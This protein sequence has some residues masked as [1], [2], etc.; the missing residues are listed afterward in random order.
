MNKRI[1]AYFGHHKCGSTWI[2]KVISQVCRHMGIQHDHYYSPKK[3]G[4]SKNEKNT[5]DKVMY[6]LN[7]D[8]IGYTGADLR[9][10][11]DI[12]KFRGVHIIRDPRDIITSAYFSHL[13][14][15]STSGWPELAKF[16][17][18]I[19][20]MSKEEGFLLNID[21]TSRLP[22]DGLDLDLFKS[23]EEWNYKTS[24]ILEMKYEDII[25][26]PYKSF[27][28][29]FDHFGFTAHVSINVIN[30]IYHTLFDSMQRVLRLLN[31]SIKNKKIP[32]WYILY[33]VYYND[34]SR[35]ARGR[36]QGDENTKSHFRKG[37]SG[38]W[39]NHFNDDHKDYFKKYYNEILVKLGY[40]N[41]DK[42]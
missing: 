8:F 27:I 13:H 2:M 12:N 1:P 19:G 32:E 3:W 31:L 18:E 40:E 5:L 42:W 24:N 38:D 14:S 36:T 34:F 23:M 25:I 35:L 6:D 11:G 20:N 26:N 9:Y 39:K 29:I 7:S 41:D 30:I 37:I 15:H 16:R 17:K 21:F 10:I 28:Q 4:Y 22:V 33:C